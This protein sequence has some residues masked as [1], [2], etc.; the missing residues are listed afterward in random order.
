MQLEQ[1]VSAEHIFTEYAYF[2]SFSD[3][4]VAARPGLHREDDRPLRPRRP[5]SSVVELAS[6]DGYLL[7]WFVKAGVPALGIEPAANVAA[8]A[9]DTG[10]AHAGALLRHASWPASSWP[11]AARPTCC[12][13]TT[14]WPRCPDLND[15][16]AGM[17]IVLAP[18]GVLTMEFP[19]VLRLIDEN[20]FDTIYH[21]HFCYFS[22]HTT[23]TI[24]G[25]HG[26]DRRRRSRRLRGGR[27]RRGSR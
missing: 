20:Q 4:W 24:F 23:R 18:E 22:L 5:D 15:F 27:G 8:A 1:Y 26:L 19:H 13:A 25:H 16:V 12:S 11:R 14:C 10:R 21:E 3:S 9:E 7:Q 17:K 6:N 2:S